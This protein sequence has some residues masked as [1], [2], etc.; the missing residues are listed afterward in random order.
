M[1]IGG[2]RRGPMRAASSTSGFTKG[3]EDGSRLD[4]WTRN[5][6]VSVRLALQAGRIR[7][8]AAASRRWGD[9]LCFPGT[10][11]IRAVDRLGP[12]LTDQL[13]S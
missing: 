13:F 12:A 3:G 9:G 5:G 10:L 8:A 6:S 11:C 7:P 4:D 2:V 1:L